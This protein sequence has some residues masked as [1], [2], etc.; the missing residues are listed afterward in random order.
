MFLISWYGSCVWLSRTQLVFHITVV[1]AETHYPPPHCA[2]IN[3]LVS[4]NVQEFQRV[5]FFSLGGIQFHTFAP[6]AVPCQ[7]PFC[8]TA[9]LLPSVTQQQNVTEYW[10]E[11]STSTST[12]PTSACDSV[13][14]NNEIGGITSGAALLAIKRKHCEKNP[15][16]RITLFYHFPFFIRNH[17]GTDIILAS[18]VY[19]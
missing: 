12:P 5:P 7:I 1:T 10:W 18:L 3:C 16:G 13:G 4:I 17:W 19:H 9:P 14:Q 8:Q 11:G 15:Q 2:H 6:Y